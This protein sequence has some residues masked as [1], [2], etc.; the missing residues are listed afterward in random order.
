MYLSVTVDRGAV[1]VGKVV[2]VVVVVVAVAGQGIANPLFPPDHRLRFAGD[3]VD[4]LW[5]DG[6][7]RSYPETPPATLW[8]AELI[9]FVDVC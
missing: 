4:W 2:V 3:S 5:I 6:R 8:N 9:T 7:M 1:A